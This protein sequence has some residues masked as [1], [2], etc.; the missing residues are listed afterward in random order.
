MSAGVRH[1]RAWRLAQREAQ[2][3]RRRANRSGRVAFAAAATVITV[4]RHTACEEDEV[5][6]DAS[7]GS[8]W[9]LPRPRGI[10]RQPRRRDVPICS[11]VDVQNVVEVRALPRRVRCPLLSRQASVG[12]AFL[13]V[14]ER[15]T[16]SF[17][18][19]LNPSF[20]PCLTERRSAVCL[21]QLDV[22]ITGL[23]SEGSCSLREKLATFKATRKCHRGVSRPAIVGQPSN[24][25]W[26]AP[27]ATE[28]WR[29]AEAEP[30]LAVLFS[31]SI[32]AP[33]DWARRGPLQ[34]AFSG[35]V[36]CVASRGLLIGK[37]AVYHASQRGRLI[38][39][40]RC[41]ETLPRR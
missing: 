22:Q 21:C 39:T 18:F 25:P 14:I 11:H 35:S 2:E 34:S 31:H 37:A 1:A 15:S 13:F 30:R 26:C 9:R 3:G 33:V 10:G 20:S 41:L 23:V 7:H 32:K 17:C 19:S 8:T 29:P 38:Q 5:E 12:L 36:P 27:L 40:F 24:L 6:R 28:D 16:A 4:T